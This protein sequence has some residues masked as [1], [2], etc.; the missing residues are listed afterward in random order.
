MCEP[1]MIMA[2]ISAITSIIA[3]QQEN[4]SKV[5]AAGIE[6]KQASHNMEALRRRQLEEREGSASRLDQ[7]ERDEFK[8]RGFAAVAGAE[9]GVVPTEIEEQLSRDASD[10][11]FAEGRSQANRELQADRSVLGIGLGL[12]GSRSRLRPENMAPTV[13]AG[14]AGV[15]AA[16]FEPRADGTTFWGDF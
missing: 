3:K 6:G 7:I 14:V 4:K 12:E 2:G 8:A 16:G 10:L 9:A 5:R 13:L 11:L 1:T 15:G